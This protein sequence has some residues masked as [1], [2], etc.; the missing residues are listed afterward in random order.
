MDKGNLEAL[1][2]NQTF[3]LVYPHSSQLGVIRKLLKILL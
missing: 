3:V 1:D 2:N